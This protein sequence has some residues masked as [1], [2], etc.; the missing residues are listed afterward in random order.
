MKKE[1]RKMCVAYGQLNIVMHLFL[2]A[3][4]KRLCRQRKIGI[5]SSLIKMES[6]SGNLS[7]SVVTVLP[8]IA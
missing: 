6:K 7:F 3:K 1:R 2:S 8:L 4:S 5:T